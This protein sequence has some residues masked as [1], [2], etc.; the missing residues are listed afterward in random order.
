MKLA[1]GK[2]DPKAFEHEKDGFEVDTVRFLKA[3]SSRKKIQA[4]ERQIYEKMCQILMGMHP[5][6]ELKSQLEN[7]ISTLDEMI[8]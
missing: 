3:I 8:S 1:I 7:T 5:E 4:E 2:N 6:N